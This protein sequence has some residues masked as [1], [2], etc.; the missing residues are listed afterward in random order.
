MSEILLHVLFSSFDYFDFDRDMVEIWV[1]LTIKPYFN[2]VT[3][4]AISLP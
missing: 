3:L 1:D 2:K 4:F